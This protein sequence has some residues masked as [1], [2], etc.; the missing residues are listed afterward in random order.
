MT[1]TASETGAE[2]P[3][4]AYVNVTHSTGRPR[5]ARAGL[6]LVHPEELHEILQDAVGQPLVTRVVLFRP[7]ANPGLPVRA[8]DLLN[9]VLPG[10]HHRLDD[11]R[12]RLEVV[13][14]PEQP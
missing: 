6:R 14:E 9:V 13:L 10:R 8:E 2:A 3:I 11:L 7:L 1:W 5:G 12:R 4:P